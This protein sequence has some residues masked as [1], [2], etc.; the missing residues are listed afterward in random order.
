MYRQ[1]VID[2][3]RKVCMRL[4]QTRKNQGYFF[5]DLIRHCE[6]QIHELEHLHDPFYFWDHLKGSAKEYMIHT[7]GET[8][9]D[10]PVS[11]VEKAEKMVTAFYDYVWARR[12]LI[13]AVDRKYDRLY[14][15]SSRELE[16]TVDA[17]KI[18]SYDDFINIIQVELD[19]P[20]DCEGMVDRHLDWI[21]DL[22]WLPFESYVFTITNSKV[23]MKRNPKLL[24]EIVDHFNRIIIPFWDHEVFDVVVGGE[25]KDIRL[26]L[27]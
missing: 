18:R 10:P 8:Y 3:V 9:P 2:Q 21:R 24:E 27:L 26:N 12:K 23:L 14:R 5:D 4:K 17:S 1:P 15:N 20:H 6:Y 11:E 16:V 25:R 22:G 13:R 19:Y 7:V